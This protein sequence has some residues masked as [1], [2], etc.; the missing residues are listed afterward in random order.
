MGPPEIEF[1]ADQRL[2]KGDLR[3]E[4]SLVEGEDEGEPVRAASVVV[5]EDGEERSVAWPPTS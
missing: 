5:R 3:C 2:K 4:A 1:E